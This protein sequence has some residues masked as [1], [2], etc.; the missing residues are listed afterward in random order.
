MDYNGVNRGGEGRKGVKVFLYSLSK[1]QVVFI[2]LCSCTHDIIRPATNE[3][4]NQSH[5]DSTNGLMVQSSAVCIINLAIFPS[6]PPAVEVS[7][8]LQMMSAC[9][10]ERRGGR[11]REKMILFSP[12][13]PN[14]TPSL[15]SSLTPNLHTV[16]SLT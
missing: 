3:P 13:H 7:W 15:P 8:F 10:T 12:C 14:P 1:Y 6:Q 9:T 11:G 5:D 4:T 2:P 16:L